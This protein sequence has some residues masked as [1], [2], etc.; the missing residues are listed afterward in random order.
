MV[1]FGA[2]LIIDSLLLHAL[3]FNYSVF[4]L[5]ALDPYVQHWMIGIVFIVVGLVLPAGKGFPI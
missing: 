2:Y 5:Q 4:N 3:N 1:L